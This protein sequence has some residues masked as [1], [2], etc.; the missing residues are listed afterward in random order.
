LCQTKQKEKRNYGNCEEPNTK[1]R[2]TRGRGGEERE[3]ESMKTK[4]IILPHCFNTHF[5]LIY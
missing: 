1:K 5:N 3:R 4:H 2:E